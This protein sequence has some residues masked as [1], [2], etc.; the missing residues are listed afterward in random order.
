[1]AAAEGGAPV[2]S[3]TTITR[4]E[5]AR[6]LGVNKSTVIR[7]CRPGGR[8]AAAVR[9]GAVDVTHPAVRRWLAERD[10]A[11]EAAAREAAEHGD[12]PEPPEPP[13][14]EPEP[15]PES[16]PP[17]TL[18]AA[19]IDDLDLGE[20]E[21][22]PLGELKERF[23]SHPALAGWFRCLKTL[24]ETRHKRNLRERYEGKFVA[25]STVIRMIDHVDGAFRLILSDAPRSIATRLSLPD[26]AAG[27][28]LIRDLLTQTLEA[29]REHMAASLEGDDPVAAIMEA[30]E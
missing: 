22:T 8:I 11:R 19:W 18:P 4:A 20:I 13:G 26:T 21:A 27:A 14:P 10:G 1:M 6:R 15:E 29:A 28:A 17:P 5:L 23:G 2:A 16:D 7:A 25:R 9:R 3:G 12:G 24:E 30:A